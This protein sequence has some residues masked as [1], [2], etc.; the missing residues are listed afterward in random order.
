MLIPAQFPAG[1][2]LRDVLRCASTAIPSLHRTS[3]LV[4]HEE[5]IWSLLLSR[6][7]MINLAERKQQDWIFTSLFY[8]T[9]KS[10]SQIVRN[11][12]Q[13]PKLHLSSSHLAAYC[14]C[15]LFKCILSLTKLPSAKQS[16]NATFQLLTPSRHVISAL[17]LFKPDTWLRPKACSLLK[18]NAWT[19]RPSIC[20]SRHWPEEMQSRAQRSKQTEQWHLA[21]LRRSKYGAT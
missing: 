9:N 10:I 11:I 15:R 16:A 2:P 21:G 12:S 17:Q 18:T 20:T 6:S 19:V 7:G 13:N 4:L 8:F 14:T 5:K 1:L 3:A